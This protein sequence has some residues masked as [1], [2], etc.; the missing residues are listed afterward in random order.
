[1][2]YTLAFWSGADSA[3]CADVYIRLNSG[4]HVDGVASV[5]PA[6]VLRSLDA[7]EGWSR[8]ENMVYPPGGTADA[9]PAFDTFIDT[10][11]VVFTGYH[12]Q[13]HDI[14]VVIDVMREHGCRLYDPQTLERFA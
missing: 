13:A 14:N 3:E 6:A 4:E 11:F 5:D 1:M 2:S 12:V 9:R 10:Q 7:L 8:H